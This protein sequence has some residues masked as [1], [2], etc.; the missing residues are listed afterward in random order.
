MRVLPTTMLFAAGPRGQLA[1]FTSSYCAQA[2]IRM[3]VLLSIFSSF[4]NNTPMVSLLL[5]IIKDWARL[6]GFPPSWCRMAS[7]PA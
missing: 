5:P 2:T 7:A 4:F 6:R 3:C 1:S